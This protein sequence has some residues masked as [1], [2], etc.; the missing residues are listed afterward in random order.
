MGQK[1]KQEAN[2]IIMELN[3]NEN[4]AQENFWDTLKSVLQGEFIVL[5]AFIKE[6]KTQLMT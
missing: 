6:I 4:M 5:S 3:E 1:K 2:K